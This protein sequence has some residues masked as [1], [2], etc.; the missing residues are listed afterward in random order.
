MLFK[1]D[2]KCK[3]HAASSRLGAGP[4][5][6]VAPAGPLHYRCAV[7]RAT[8]QWNLLRPHTCALR[9]TRIILN[10][11]LPRRRPRCQNLRN[12]PDRLLREGAV[13]VIPS[14][15]CTLSRHSLFGTISSV[16]IRGI[17]FQLTDRHLPWVTLL[18]RIEKTAV[19]PWYHANAITDDSILIDSSTSS[20]SSSSRHPALILAASCVNL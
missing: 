17:V 1:W 15:R 16:D 20:S 4:S 3:L 9:A 6:L 13:P 10:H 11:L 19:Y 12:K 7:A 2:R 8:L 14:P 18:F 5:R